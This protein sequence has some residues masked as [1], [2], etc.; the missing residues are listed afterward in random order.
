VTWFSPGGVGFHAGE[1][2]AFT[3]VILLLLALR[4]ALL[5]LVPRLFK[6]ERGTDE[7][8]SDYWRIHGG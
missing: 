6:R 7:S 3:L 8:E 1:W 2:L 4:V 5:R